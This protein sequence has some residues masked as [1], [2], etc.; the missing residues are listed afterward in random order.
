MKKKRRL[1]SFLLCG[2]ML[3][4]LCTQP[5]SA[6][7]GGQSRDGGMAKRAEGLCEHHTRHDADCGYA[8][9]AQGTDCTHQHT[10]DC[11]TEVTRCVYEHEANGGVSDKDST[12]SNATK[13]E[14]EEEAHICSEESG[15]ITEKLNCQHEHRPGSGGC[16]YAP[17]SEGSPC[18]YVCEI[19]GQ[20]D[21]VSSGAEKTA[22]AKGVQVMI[23]AL[24]C[25]KEVKEMSLDG[26]REIY[27]NLQAAY[28]AY[29]ALSGEE[30]GQIVG[31]EVFEELF[32]WFNSLIAPLDESSASGDFG[33]NL[34]WS[35]SLED[36]TL[37][38][39]GTG[40]MPDFNSVEDRPWY[41][42]TTYI[43]KLIIEEGVTSIGKLAFD[44]AAS[45][46]E[47][48]LPD[49][50]RSI[51]T[52][53]F[54]T[55][56]NL[57]RIELPDSIESI[58]DNAFGACEELQLEK[59]PDNLT[60]IGGNAFHD[61]KNLTLTEL[62][63]KVT[64]IGKTAFS[65]C[66]SLALTRLPEG[67]TEI[68]NQAFA[69]C[70]ALALTELPDSVET[71]GLRSFLYCNNI[72]LTKF[73]ASLTEIGTRAFEGCQGLK[74]LEMPPSLTLMMSGAFMDC[75]NL[76]SITFTG[77]EAPTLEADNIFRWSDSLERIYILARAKG[78]DH[79]YWPKE[80]FVKLYSVTLETEGS[81]TATASATSATEGT[82]IILTAEPGRGYH[83]KEWQVVSGNVTISGNQFTLP[84]EAVSIK[85]VFEEN[86][87]T[88]TVE[89]EGSGTASASATSAAE[90]TEIILAAEPGSGYHFKEWQVISGNI[91][92]NGNR[93]TMPPED[94]SIKAVFEENTY[95]V[96]V[97]AE[98][99]GT[100][101]ASVTSATESTEI[102]LTAEPGRG[103]HFKEWQVVSGNVTING[104]QFTMPSE[105]VSIKAV[106][107]K[108]TYSVTVETEGVG[109]ASASL[110]SAEA[111]TEIILTAE[112][113]S[114]Y[115]FKEWQVV[116]GSI[117]VSGNSFTMPERDVTVKAV[118]EKDS[119]SPQ[120]P[121]PPKPTK[122][123]V[124]VEAEGN[125]TA[126]ASLISAEAGTKVTLTAE[127]GSGYHF[128]EWQVVSGSVTIS[129]N[130][131]IMPEG[132]VTVKAI[133]EKDT[134]SS[135]SGGSNGRSSRYAAPVYGQG[136]SGTGTIFTDIKETDGFY[137]DVMFA[138]EHGLLE[139]V[140]KTTFSPHSNA[141][142]IQLAPIFYR[143]EGSPKVEG[144][145]GF[146]DVEY[147]PGSI[148]NYDA[149]TWVQ[150]NGIMDSY[151]NDRFG[152]GDPVSSEELAVILYRYAKYKGYDV[153]AAGN[154]DQF[155]DKDSVSAWAQEALIWAVSSGIVDGTENN[156][157]TPQGT[158]TRS[159]LA[160]IIRRFIEKYA[161]KPVPTSS[162]TTVWTNQ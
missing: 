136:N 51:G 8:E 160:A 118:F 70:F 147:G 114:G 119:T 149:V 82:E 47:I 65:H 121:E 59:L 2:T 123:S 150:R 63:D 25:V 129:G 33:D 80:K 32:G 34:H 107:E 22:A 98:G 135:Y 49:G 110:T 90:G 29:E 40:D 67:L 143:M 43:H 55:C 158:V 137:Q 20:E 17:A 111:G 56:S 140:G 99:S 127:A 13:Q 14:P 157:L 30:Q 3:F 1:L 125:G 141:P 23:D 139:S 102:T 81:G 72:A 71:I 161:L 104:N 148:R 100:A 89:A 77:E 58:G 35:W 116:S 87:Y 28:D 6:G 94:V 16:G 120:P 18:G 84:P 122:Y 5:V 103:Y 106:F 74:H 91:T 96:T 38:I 112:A 57:K 15:C 19:C 44:H 60:E 39:T 69:Y 54:S 4:S 152:S 36:R 109:T 62:P 9:E 138:Y 75:P 159:Q 76:I 53:A 78:Y 145:N 142:R 83:F 64:S 50:L 126:S 11:Y 131:F 46:E 115:H 162:G 61:C 154:L 68:E 12:P 79:E 130:R 132:N 134:G 95:T 105:D 113:G 52:S 85:A 92:I 133:F 151:G 117:T 156:L 101:S 45:L 7:T 97:E 73:P 128:K 42:K 31:I 48:E 21:T 26:Q 86:T 146:T 155:A 144:K 10:K 124:M 93:F 37:I 41:G 66:E 27:G 24:P 88:V 153:A 108:D